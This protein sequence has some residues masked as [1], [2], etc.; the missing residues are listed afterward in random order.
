MNASRHIAIAALVA[1][2]QI[3]NAPPSHARALTS[4]TY[5]VDPAH[6]GNLKMKGFAPPLKLLWSRTL[7]GS[8]SYPIVANDMVFVTVNKP[9]NAGTN[10]A[11]FDVHSGRPVWREP[12]ADNFGATLAYDNGLIFAI[13]SQGLLRAI[14][15]QD[16]TV[17]YTKQL[18]FPG[19]PVAR[20]GSL[21]V[22]GAQLVSI[23]EASGNIQWTAS[24]RQG[25]YPALGD[26]GVY[27]TSACAYFKFDALTGQQKWVYYFGCSSGGVDS[28]YFSN[29]LYVLDTAGPIVVDTASGKPV[30]I[31]AA[32]A[33]PAFYQSDSGK[34]FEYTLFNNHLY[35]I[36][37]ATGNVIWSFVG[38]GQLSSP[39]IVINGMVIEGSALGNLYLL[40]GGNGA[41]L[42]S[43]N[44]GTPIDANCPGCLRGLGGGDG[45]LIVPAGQQISAY[46]S[47]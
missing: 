26:G 7:D 11:A 19:L 29:R 30:D 23:E 38:D 17:L 43:T 24:A 12:V 36:D 15:A 20:N 44:V 47:N 16:G 6:D 3:L 31:L 18:Q 14:T 5:Q 13:T 33:T 22:G 39:P 37:L 1:A 27:I 34:Q 2:I 41:A 21:Y 25:E 35:G 10:L 32:D 46:A 40:N 4:T 8:L 45:T 9:D 28:A 42:W